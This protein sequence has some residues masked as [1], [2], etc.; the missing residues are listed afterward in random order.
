MGRS[1]LHCL[2]NHIICYDLFH[3]IKR[4]SHEESDHSNT[5]RLQYNSAAKHDMKKSLYHLYSLNDLVIN[6]VI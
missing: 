5:V 3:L 1:P 6:S 2:Y 4:C